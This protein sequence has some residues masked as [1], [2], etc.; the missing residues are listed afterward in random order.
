MSGTSMAAPHVTGVAA[1]IYAAARDV[2]EEP[3][4]E[5]VAKAILEG[6]EEGGVSIAGR[7]LLNAPAALRAYFKKACD[8]SGASSGSANVCTQTQRDEP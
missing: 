3:T 5:E 2:D 4:A 8:R 6:A 7:Y 1:L